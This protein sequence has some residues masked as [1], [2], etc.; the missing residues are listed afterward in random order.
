MLRIQHDR[1]YFK[2]V[3][4]IG[5]QHSSPE[6]ANGTPQLPPP[7]GPFRPPLPRTAKQTPTAP[8]STSP[9][10]LPAATAEPVRLV[11]VLLPVLPRGAKRTPTAPHSRPAPPEPVRFLVLLFPNQ[12]P[13][14]I[15][16]FGGQKNPE[17]GVAGLGET[18]ESLVK[19]TTEI[20]VFIDFNCTANFGGAT[21]IQEKRQLFTGGGTPFIKGSPTLTLPSCCTISV[22]FCCTPPGLATLATR[23]LQ[24]VSLAV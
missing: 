18:Q 14:L 20:H 24:P 21:A 5:V 12:K 10:T 1:K 13:L 9:K 6:E 7:Q 23:S 17:T 16:W 22:S 8:H 3:G 11:A 19:A 15:G 4:I 2:T